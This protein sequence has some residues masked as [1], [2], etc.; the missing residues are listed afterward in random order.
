MLAWITNHFTKNWNLHIPV[1]GGM[2]VSA[3]SGTSIL[4]TVL[5]GTAMLIVAAVLRKM[6]PKFF[7][8]GDKNK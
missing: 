3:I 5:G 6:F 7:G 2:S 4:N 8:N 1:L